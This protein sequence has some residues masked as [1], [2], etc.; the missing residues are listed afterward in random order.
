MSFQTEF[1]DEVVKL[2]MWANFPTSSR[3][4][5]ALDVDG[6]V[7]GWGFSS[8]VEYSDLN[9]MTSTQF[10]PSQV[11]DIIFVMNSIGEFQGVDKRGTNVMLI[12]TNREVNDESITFW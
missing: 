11:N 3:Q 9:L 8:N 5:F 10:S 4:G 6:L 7:I 1:F 2:A 12:K